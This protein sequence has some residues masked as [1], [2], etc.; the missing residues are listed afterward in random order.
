M[1][2][3]TICVI[4][5]EINKTDCFALQQKISVPAT[6]QLSVRE[7]EGECFTMLI[8]A[9]VTDKLN[10]LHARITLTKSIQINQSCLIRC[11]ASQ[12]RW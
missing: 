7:K 3:I 9:D 12:L 6:A 5:F 2:L 8:Y 10:K 11:K 4:L 1:L